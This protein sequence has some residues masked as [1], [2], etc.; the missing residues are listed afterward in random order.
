M[1]KLT[2]ELRKFEG[3]KNEVYLDPLGFPT[4]GVGHHLYAG[5]KVPPECVEA[6]FKADVADAISEFAKLPL[7]Y[8]KHLNP[9]R[10]RVIT[11]LL[12]W[13]GL[14][15]VL[16]FKKMWKAIEAD[17]FNTAADELT[18]SKLYEQV[19]IRCLYLANQ[20]RKGD[21]HVPD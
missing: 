1:D 11:H 14:P 9:D 4:C 19:P 18:N 8:R 15:R 20:L 10:R 7:S 3:V 6:F 2:D 17:D 5:S 12:F 21:N 16:G 13:I